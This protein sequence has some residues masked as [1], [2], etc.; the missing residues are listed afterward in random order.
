MSSSEIPV[1]GNDNLGAEDVCGFCRAC[2][3][4]VFAVIEDVEKRL[5]VSL[6]VSDL[7]SEGRGTVRRRRVR[8][9][10]LLESAG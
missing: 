4:E 9:K 10:A 6:L 7:G 2:K 5:L 8:P 3:D 1:N